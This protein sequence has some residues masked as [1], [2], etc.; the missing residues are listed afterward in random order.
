M[1]SG[2][3]KTNPKVPN[4]HPSHVFFISSWQGGYRQKAYDAANGAGFS[5]DRHENWPATGGLPLDECL[6]RVSK[7][8]V[9][10]VIIAHRYGWV[11][12]EQG[13]GEYKGITWL[14]CEEAISEG[15]SAGFSARSRV[16]L[17]S[18]LGEN[19]LR[20]PLQTAMPQKSC[21]RYAP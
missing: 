5:A 17:A 13:V 12:P 15:E 3:A 7:A 4:T 20:S 6:K 1:P 9:L 21:S 2:L 11:P 14:E 16:R 18:E 19:P 8:D 10:V